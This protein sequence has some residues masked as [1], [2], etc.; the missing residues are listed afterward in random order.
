[1]VQTTS[2]NQR[3]V[4]GEDM[5]VEKF[6]NTAL[7]AFADLETTLMPSEDLYKP[8][9]IR[10]SVIDDSEHLKIIT[11]LSKYKK[12]IVTAINCFEDEIDRENEMAQFSR[13]FYEMDYVDCDNENSFD[14]INSLRIAIISKV[15]P[16]N[17]AE[18]VCLRVTFE[19]LMENFNITDKKFNVIM[20]KIEKHFNTIGPLS[21]INHNI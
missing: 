21:E 3:W 16:Y 5:I 7:T 17:L 20:D 15:E 9:F 13:F 12:H 19:D 18:L 2:L 8:L 6:A 10:D 11:L 4:S 1:M 14:I